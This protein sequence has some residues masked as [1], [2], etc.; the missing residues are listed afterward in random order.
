MPRKAKP[1]KHSSA[2]LNKRAAAS[3]VRRSTLRSRGSHCCG[4]DHRG[5]RSIQWR[6][7]TAAVVVVVR[8]LP[9]FIRSICETLLLGAHGDNTSLTSTLPTAPAPRR[10]RHAGPLWAAA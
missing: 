8:W 6:A 10:P 2:E 5:G 3:L 4:S 1:T 7:T 9:F